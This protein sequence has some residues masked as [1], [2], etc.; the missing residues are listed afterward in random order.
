MDNGRIYNKI[1]LKYIY[2]KLVRTLLNQKYGQ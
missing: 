1:R 2:F